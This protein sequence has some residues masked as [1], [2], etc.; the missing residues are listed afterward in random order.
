MP[1]QVEKVSEAIEFAQLVLSAEPGSIVDV[2]HDFNYF[3]RANKHK[4]KLFDFD[5]ESEGRVVYMGPGKA[6]ALQ[7]KTPLQ[8]NRAGLFPSHNTPGIFNLHIPSLPSLSIDEYLSWNTIQDLEDNGFSKRTFILTKKRLHCLSEQF[9]NLSLNGFRGMMCLD[10]E[11]DRRDFDV[12]IK[13]KTNSNIQMAYIHPEF[14]TIQFV[15]ELYLSELMQVID[16]RHV[17]FDSGIATVINQT[18]YDSNGNLRN[19]AHVGKTGNSS[20]HNSL[21]RFDDGAVVWT[22]T[23]LKSSKSGSALLKE[24]GEVLLIKNGDYLL[25]KGAGRNLG[26]EGINSHNHTWTGSFAQEACIAEAYDKHIIRREYKS[27]VR[28]QANSIIDGA[29]IPGLEPIFKIT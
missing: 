26:A 11:S 2:S 25:S 7:L 15:Q 29:C 19:I 22:C 14:G 9:G 23:D 27:A 3:S 20:Y 28:K 10:N 1:G 18:R 13:Y 24:N 21:E 17:I 16:L 6:R 5:L 8:D 4:K 12:W